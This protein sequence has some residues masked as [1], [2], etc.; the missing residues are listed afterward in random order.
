MCKWNGFLQD[1]SLPPTGKKYIT[2]K[3]WLLLEVS[4]CGSRLE[5]RNVNS[6]P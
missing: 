2:K 6:H 5:P 3:C 4:R 1:E